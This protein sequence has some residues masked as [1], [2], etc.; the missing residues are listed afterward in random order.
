[1]GD[2]VMKLSKAQI[3]SQYINAAGRVEFLEGVGCSAKELKLS[4]QEKSKARKHLL[5]IN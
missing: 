4:I 1:M 5:G 2:L 3:V